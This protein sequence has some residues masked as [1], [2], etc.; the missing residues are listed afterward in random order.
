MLI[1][2]F[3]QMIN[4]YKT[5]KLK[6]LKIPAHQ[7]TLLYK[8]S[9]KLRS[10]QILHTWITITT[11]THKH[12]RIKITSFTRV[13]SFFTFRT[14]KSCRDTYG[15]VEGWAGFGPEELG[16]AITITSELFRQS[17]VVQLSEQDTVLRTEK[18]ERLCLFIRRKPHRF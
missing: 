4:N 6:P 18:R 1:S 9:S 15:S 17:I 16:S 5:K 14:T 13:Q 11:E 7:S 8:Q 3:N 2:E 10:F 12:H